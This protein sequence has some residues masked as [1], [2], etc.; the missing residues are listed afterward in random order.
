MKTTRRTFLVLLAPS[1]IAIAGLFGP[2][3]ARAV[4]TP[5]WRARRTTA[6]DASELAAIFNAHK[7]AGLCPYSDLVQ[8]WSAGDAQSYITIFNASV[9]VEKDGLPVAFGGLIGVLPFLV[10]PA[11]VFRLV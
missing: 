6:D 9:V 2:R 4:S 5:T 7:A 8:P 11:Q 10:S 1:P 3:A